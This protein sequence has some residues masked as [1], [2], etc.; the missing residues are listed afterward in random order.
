MRILLPISTQH[1][2]HVLKPQHLK[3]Y[4]FKIKFFSLSAELTKG[5]L[6][7][8]GQ[9]KIIFALQRRKNENFNRKTLAQ[10]FSLGINE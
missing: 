5:K 10:K 9:V 1:R 8:F 4:N 2:T 6:L 3:F 7:I